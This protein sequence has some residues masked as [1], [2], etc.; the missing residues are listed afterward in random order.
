MG[1][2]W[3]GNRHSV[4]S[5]LGASNHTDKERQEHDYY[6]TDPI[7]LE[8]LTSVCPIRRK[9][10]EP[11]CGE[12]HLSKWL[13]EHG[14]DVLSTDLIDRGYGHGGIDF[15]KVGSGELFDGGGNQLFAEWR[16]AGNEPFDIVT[17]PPYKISTPFILHALDLVPNDGCVIMLL[18]T[19]YLEGKE[20][21]RLIYDVNPPRYIFQFSSRVVCAKNGDFEGVK[22]VGSAQAYC[23][24]VWNKEN[25]EHITEVKWIL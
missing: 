20:R 24:M 17:N 7:A 19:T 16:G 23:F 25:N 21:K 9:V 14:H 22:K 4:W 15:L 11:A 12:G 2:D 3:A 13:I 10:W 1:K 5:A 18:K 8:K 6:A